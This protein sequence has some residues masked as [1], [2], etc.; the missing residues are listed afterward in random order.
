MRF[1]AQRN[2]PTAAY[3]LPFPV[4]NLGF[5]EARAPVDK[6]EWVTPPSSI[7]L[8]TDVRGFFRTIFSGF[9]SGY[10]VD[11]WLNRQATMTTRRTE[12]EETNV[13]VRA[14]IPG[15]L[16]NSISTE[17]IYNKDKNALEI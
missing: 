4:F 8:K 6:E 14:Y 2:N 11:K 7:A 13:T 12:H 17:N 16:K 9:E 3:A 1:T 15:E 5:R 10:V